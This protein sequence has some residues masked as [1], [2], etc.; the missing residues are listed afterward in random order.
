MSAYNS[1]P[2]RTTTG[3]F[4]QSGRVRI[5]LK[6]S[7]PV[8]RGIFKSEQNQGRPRVVCAIRV[9]AGAVQI[10]HCLV[11]IVDVLEAKSEL[12]LAHGRFQQSGVV[13]II[14]D[15]QDGQPGWTGNLPGCART[16]GSQGS[17][18]AVLSFHSQGGRA[19]LLANEIAFALTMGRLDF[20]LIRPGLKKISQII[21]CAPRNGAFV[22]AAWH[23]RG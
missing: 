16:A 5:H 9:V 21:L 8:A 12:G 22:R 17:L 13:R 23:G 15:M 10:S 20:T 14:V 3:R 18:R 2:D 4:L 1:E 7:K 11:T 6:I 19:G